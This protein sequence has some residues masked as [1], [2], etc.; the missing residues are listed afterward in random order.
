MSEEETAEVIPTEELD[1]FMKDENE[2]SAPPEVEAPTEPAEEPVE[3][4]EEVQAEPEP[5]ISKGFQR[6]IDKR[7]AD[8]YREKEAREAAEAEIERLKVQLQPVE[9][10]PTLEQFDYDEASYQRALVKHYAK[11]EVQAIRQEAEIRNQSEAKRQ[12]QEAHND[13][14]DKANIEG[15]KEKVETLVTSFPNSA[16]IPMSMIEAL[17]LDEKGPEITAYLSDHLEKAHEIASMSPLKIATQIG[18]LS[19]QLSA[20][21]KKKITNAPDPVKPLVSGGTVAKKV[22]DMDMDSIMA[23]D[24]I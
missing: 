2:E 17:Q 12:A 1:A 4:T 9:A 15:Y 10:E 21:P 14:V 16:P 8:Y 24:S 13:R 7:T 19:A 20:T 11:Q 6:R 18:K 5:E 23:D 22:E 3:E